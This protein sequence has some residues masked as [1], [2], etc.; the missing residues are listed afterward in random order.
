MQQG[1]HPPPV[2]S[3][4]RLAAATIIS[5]QRARMM[6]VSLAGL[7]FRTS[8]WPLIFSRHGQHLCPSPQ[9]LPSCGERALK[10]PWGEALRVVGILDLLIVSMH[11]HA[12][13][14]W[15]RRRGARFPRWKAVINLPRPCHSPVKDAGDPGIRKGCGVVVST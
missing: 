14:S 10:G 15:G 6:Y 8:R 3:I 2:V 13:K 9:L 5:R 7:R 4:D 11:A 12:S 1:A